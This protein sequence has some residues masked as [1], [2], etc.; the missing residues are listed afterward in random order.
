M[1][2]TLK[3]LLTRLEHEWAPE[4]LKVGSTMIFYNSLGWLIVGFVALALTIIGTLTSIKY[5]RLD[6]E[7]EQTDISGYGVVGI[8]A[9]L[10]A[11]LSLLPS[12]F[13]LLDIWNWVGVFDPKIAL[14]KRIFEAT[15][16]GRL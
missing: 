15:I 12:L 10:I 4:L 16:G 14:A 5:I 1:E 7:L 2:D 3:E 9:G 13:I 6:I 8:I 11:T